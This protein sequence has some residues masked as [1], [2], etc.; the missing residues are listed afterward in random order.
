M[1][2]SASTGQD[3]DEVIAMLTDLNLPR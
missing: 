2:V 3:L 1:P